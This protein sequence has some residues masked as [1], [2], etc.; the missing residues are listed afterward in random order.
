MGRTTAIIGG[1]YSGAMLAVRLAEAGATAVLIEKSGEFGRGAAYSARCDSLVLYVRSGRMSARAD[2]PDHFIRWLAAHH[3]ALADPQGFAPRRLYGDYLQAILAGAEATA[4]GT[5]VRVAEPALGVTGAGVRMPRGRNIEADAVVLATGNPQ[6]APLGPGEH[7]NIIANPWAAEALEAVRPS[8]NIALLGAGLTMVDVMLALEDRGW[9]GR[10]T[11]LSRRGLL[12]RAHDPTQTPVEPLR[13]PPGSLSARLREVRRRSEAEGWGAVM[14]R[15]R[16]ANAETWA[17]LSPAERARFLRHLRPMWDVHRHRLAPEPARRIARLIQ[18]QR[19]LV[20]AGR[21]VRIEPTAAGVEVLWTRRG[22]PRIE[23]LTADRLV[24][25]TGPGFREAAAADRLL[26]GLVA[27]GLAR[28]D[29]LGLGLEV[30]VEGALVGADGTASTRLFALGPPA[31][32]ALWECVA[33]PDIRERI[34]AL[35]ARLAA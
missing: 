18:D 30:T 5:I 33:V 13:L 7:P 20:A 6:P 26:A 15:L 1:G 34:E 27:D 19:L 17:A 2:D 14:D 9:V 12:P 32:A 3:P 35:V 23:R 28:P 10:A 8:D 11:A 21:T 16:H 24:N 25:C 4:P 29:P 22:D 31:R